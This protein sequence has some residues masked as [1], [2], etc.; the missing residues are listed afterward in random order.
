LMLNQYD[1]GEQGGRA[2]FDPAKL[3]LSQNFHESLGVKKAL[4]TVP[5]RKPGKQDFVRVH[6]DPTY[7]LETA[8]L[9][10]NEEREIYLVAT[11][12]WSEL[13]GEITP[14]VL[15]TAITRQ[16]VTFLWPVRLAGPDGRMDE[17]NSSALEAARMAET[18]WVR[19]MAN[20]H[21]GA[22]EILYS[23]A[24]IPDPEWPE[25]TFSTL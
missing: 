5:V 14:M 6:S 23:T 19:V 4:V 16:N 3:R 1:A 8:V 15:H 2:L 10:L 22:Y 9:N 25:A 18:R 24:D 12:L 11:E 20:M 13:S 7:R 21:L 17:W